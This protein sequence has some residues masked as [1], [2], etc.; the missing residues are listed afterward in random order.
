METIKQNIISF[1]NERG[2]PYAESSL[3]TYL[4]NIGKVY[5]QM[6]LEDPMKDME[7]AKDI[8]AVD[9][10]ISDFKPT[11][12]RNY[13]N[14]IIIGMM[15]L[16][17]GQEPSPQRKI[18]EGKRDILNA[19][20]EKNKGKP[21]ASQAKVMEQ[22]SKQTILNMLNET[23]NDVKETRIDYITWMLFKIHTQIPFR[24]ELANM[25]ILRETQYEKIADKEQNYLLLSGKKMKFV[26]N[27]GKTSQKYGSRTINV[28]EDL[29]QEITDYLK[30]MKIYKRSYTDPTFLFS[31]ATGKPFARNDVSHIMS[32]FSSKIIGHSVSTTLMA[33]LF[34]NIPENANT[35]T[36][37]E[38]QAVQEQAHARGHSVKIKASIYN[39]SIA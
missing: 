8:S 16:E 21:T 39:P 4:R 31:W 27:T 15:A 17:Q 30:H 12:Q 23:K 26:M 25:R 28:P 11:T 20:Y 22:V 13:Y 32:K 35:A 1:G 7:W 34:N 24:N 18:Y 2:R 29:T 9:K 37:E 33:K 10:A 5:S 36:A 19:E 3:T 14:S 6:G 38:I